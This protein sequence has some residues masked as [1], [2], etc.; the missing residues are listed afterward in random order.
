MSII[1][2]CSWGDPRFLLPV[3]CSRHPSASMTPPSVAR[4]GE[5]LQPPQPASRS[6]L[7]L[8]SP[9]PGWSSTKC[10]QMRVNQSE[11]ATEWKRHSKKVNKP[12]SGSV[13]KWKW[14]RVKAPQNERVTERN[15]HSAKVSQS[16]S[17]T[18][19]KQHR[20]IAPQCE[21]ATVWGWTTQLVDVPP[22]ERK[23]VW[24]TGCYLIM[25]SVAKINWNQAKFKYC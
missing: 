7:E 1:W 9:I 6:P 22:N 11:S 23:T 18:E 5:E 24:N 13:T 8:L 17:K 12:P 14:I 19:W 21:I 20:M 4:A 3:L 16:E 2:T 25:K 15:C 10:H